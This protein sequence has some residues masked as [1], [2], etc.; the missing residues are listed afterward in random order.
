MKGTKMILNAR[1]TSSVNF[2]IHSSG[3]M[4]ENDLRK[5]PKS[6]R[7]SELLRGENNL[8]NKMLRLE[9]EFL[10]RYYWSKVFKF[11]KSV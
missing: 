11:S 7:A 8:R 2:N 1:V 5:S 9:S 3:D 4:K 6:L 10:G